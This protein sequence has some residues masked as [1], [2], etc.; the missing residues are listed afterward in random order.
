M[1]ITFCWFK[2]SSE[3]KVFTCFFCQ[4]A[5]HDTTSRMGMQAQRANWTGMSRIKV[6]C[7]MLG[8][9]RRHVGQHGMARSIIRA[10]PGLP[11]RHGHDANGSWAGPARPNL[12][13]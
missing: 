4:L 5:V 2:N 3:N 9:S 12:Q 1:V 7:V 11:L 10:V 6:W 13:D 8:P